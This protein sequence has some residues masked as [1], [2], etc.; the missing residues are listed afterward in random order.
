MPEIP[1]LQVFKDNLN[2]ML[3]GHTLENIE[4]YDSK[5]PDS[6]ELQRMLK[7]EKLT[8]I[9]RE[10][11]ELYF[12]FPNDHILSLHLMLT[13]KLKLEHKEKKPGNALALLQFEPDIFLYIVDRPGYI[14]AFLTLDPEPPA[15]PDVYDKGFTL[16]Y[17]KEKLDKHKKMTIKGLMVD[18]KIM[19][20]I[21][22]AYVDEI[23]WKSKVSPM[24]KAG[25]LP[26]DVVKTIF[27]NIPKVLQDAEKYIRSVAPDSIN[28]KIRDFL[29]VHNY[30]KTETPTG[31]EIKKIKVGGRDTF[32]TDEQVLY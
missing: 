26:D 25:N 9:T 3:K 5:G 1:D 20:G 22:N 28:D 29:G 7:G 13:G 17:F 15:A 11:K 23:L 30:H 16:D 18:A 8:E 24:S 19:R 21:G 6:K 32:Y 12:H 4:A 27:K 2:K 14:R 10:G 31:F